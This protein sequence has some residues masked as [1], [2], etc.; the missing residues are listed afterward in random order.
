LV[1]VP[2][3][4]AEWSRQELKDMKKSGK[5]ERKAEERKRSWNEWVRDQRGLWG[6]PW[7][8]RKFLVWFTFG[9]IIW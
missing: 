3:M 2:A 4:G 5:A 7:L 8:T 1:T 6:I 9:F